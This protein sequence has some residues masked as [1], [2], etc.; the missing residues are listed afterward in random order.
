MKFNPD[1]FRPFRL[2]ETG[3]V[4]A[5]KSQ[6]G[7]GRVVAEDNLILSSKGGSRFEIIQIADR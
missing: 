1:L 2:E 3:R 5:I 6:F 4:I 7:V